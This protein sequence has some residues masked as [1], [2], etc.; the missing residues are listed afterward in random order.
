L[1]FAVTYGVP[2][3]YPDFVG[4]RNIIPAEWY[5][6]PY[7]FPLGITAPEFASADY[8]PIFPNIFIFFGGVFAG[9]YF[10][11]NGFPE[12]TYPQRIKPLGVLGRS[13]LIIYIAH[14]PLIYAVTEIVRLIIK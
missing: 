8:F 11:A 5:L 4:I 12:W 1:L 6:K 14:M 3:D 13:A 2:N 7:L 10:M 9:R